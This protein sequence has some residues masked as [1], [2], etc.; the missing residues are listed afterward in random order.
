[1][2]NMRYILR[3]FLFLSLH[4]VRYHS[5]GVRAFLRFFFLFPE[6]VTLFPADSTQGVDDGGRIE[7]RPA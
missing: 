7:R 6:G 4:K 2:G 5:Q 3:L 1:M